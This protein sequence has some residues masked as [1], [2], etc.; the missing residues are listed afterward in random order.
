MQIETTVLVSCVRHLWQ[1]HEDA[2]IFGVTLPDVG[3]EDLEA[4][5][6][7]PWPCWWG[8]PLWNLWLVRLCFNKDCG[9]GTSWLVFSNLGVSWDCPF[10]KLEWFWSGD[11]YHHSWCPDS[12]TQYFVKICILHNP[13]DNLSHSSGIS[14]PSQKSVL[15]SYGRQKIHWEELLVD[16]CLPWIGVRMVRKWPLEARIVC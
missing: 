8:I 12:A 6:R 1:P 10:E 5:G 7:S 15:G 9:Q 11:Y 13:R 3:Y 16:R 14:T 2:V 4:A